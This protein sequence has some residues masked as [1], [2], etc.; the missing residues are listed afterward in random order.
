MKTIFLTVT[1]FLMS[2]AVSVQAQV[3]DDFS[4]GGWTRFK[5]TP[6]HVSMDTGKLQLK[7][8]RES[9]A[10]VTVSKTFSVDVDKTPL[11]VV[12]VSSVSDRGTVKLIR[13]K[14]YDK[15]VAIEIDRPG[16]YALDMREQ[17]GWQGSVAIET[18]L[19]A[20]GAEEEITYEYVK[21]AERLSQKEKDLISNRM[22]GGNVKLNVAPFEII[23]LFNTCSFYFKSPSRD[24]LDVLYR[25]ENG[26]WLRAYTPVYVKEDGMYRGSI[27][28]L[29]EDTRYKL[30]ITAVNGDVLAQQAFR[31][32]SSQVPIGK[33]II[34]D[35][36]NFAGR[37]TVQ[38]SGSPQGWI[39]IIA[40]EGF[41]LQND[42]E[43]PLIEL[44]EAK[45]VMLEGLTLRGG[46]QE[47]ISIKRC[48]H[49]RVVN[50]D[51]AGWGR[52]G[53]Q[54]FDRDGK[55]YTETGRA[56]NW[57]SAI[58]VS[59][60]IGTVVERCYVH[61]PVSTA[62]SWYYSH[63]AGPQAVGMD[64]SRSTVLRYNDFMGS[65]QH[66]WNDAVEG[67]GNFHI[68]GGF[69]RDGDVYGNMMCFAN[70]DALE[71]DGGQ[72][73]VRVF[74]NKFEGCLCGV[75]IQG[76]MSGPSYVFRNVLVN[77]GDERGLAGQT[78]KTSSHANGPGAVSFIFNNTCYGESRDLSLRHNLRIVAKN[79]IFAGRSAISGRD[80]SPQSDCDYNLLSTGQPDDGTHSILGKPDF[81]DAHAG[82]FTLRR[83]SV[84]IGHGIS[85]DN[86]SLDDKTRPDIGAIPFG[87]DLVLPVRPIPVTLD[88]YQLMF[89]VSDVESART[90]T[91]SAT[92]RDQASSTRF[93][94]A[95][96]DA[97]DWFN[98][99]PEAGVLR[100]GQTT[101]FSVRLCPEKMTSRALYRGA[102]LIRLQNG[103]SRPV[104]VYAS[105]GVVPKIKPTNKDAWVT[106]IEA[107]GAGNQAAYR[108]V[109][110][111]G[112][113][114][115]KCLHLSGPSG[116][117][118]VEYRFSVPNTGK[119]FLLVRA[120]SDEPTGSH[121]S[122]YFG[123]D[124]GAFDRA[125]LRIAASWGWS[126]AA[127]NR[128]MSLI[129]LQAFEL[130]AGEHVVKL[131]PRE[132]LHVDLLAV[133]DNPG[134]FDHDR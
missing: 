60:S 99:T 5:S 70:D 95:K 118:P 127:H 52:V 129:C 41:V 126:L 102:F 62:N 133:T 67:A 119:Y 42:R 113:S 13:K 114:Q 26:P 35:E 115:G 109:A 24:G 125:Q 29:E 23:P 21:F 1:V 61:D 104:M 25:R 20:I 4:E 105:S 30:K 6:G 85:I 46:L 63:P 57:D 121:D 27:I 33:T 92:V 93:R 76:C 107:E 54:R 117:N 68:D 77:M 82:L 44:H 28:D 124:D 34:L 65:D 74:L 71:I 55:Y 40:K 10:W 131:A 88:R 103:Y 91:I 45:Y 100:P 47:A 49:V 19:Y 14:P 81:V 50:C 9:P 31:T 83:T 123:V 80:R 134:L 56:I 69:N 98:V 86:F 59:K 51:I 87:S 130:A 64:K 112:A 18:C 53:T 106:Y 128:K 39:K 120:K 37:L 110:D 12:K 73:N 2:S 72:T 116:K 22:A 97:F 36:S 108:T 11:F 132:S 43:G 7:D 111:S 89:S 122:L 78:I 101:T 48:E 32:W 79:N 90:G 94:I 15:R 66:R 75:S 96:N 58:L 3:V 84:A 38:E 8:G 16:L 17:F